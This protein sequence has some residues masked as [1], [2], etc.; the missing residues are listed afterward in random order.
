M[1]H[2]IPSYIQASGCVGSADSFVWD[3][4]YSHIGPEGG[5]KLHNVLHKLPT[6]SIIALGAATLEWVAWRLSALVDVQD[7]LDYA[8]SV[9]AWTIHPY[10]LIRWRVDP[11]DDPP[12]LSALLA[13]VD[14]MS[15]AVLTSFWTSKHGPDMEVFHLIH[16]TRH[17]MP[18]VDPFDSWLSLVIKRLESLAFEGDVIQHPIGFQ[19]VSLDKNLNCT[20][21]ENGS[22]VDDLV[23]SA[24]IIDHDAEIE[25]VSVRGI[26]LP[27]EVFDPSIDYNPDQ[28]IELIERFL[29]SL[30]WK[31][32][33]FLRSPASIAKARGFHG[34]PYTI[35]G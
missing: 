2:T 32:N 14:M 1:K 27:P 23:P 17:I 3:S 15:E 29:K 6:C 24:Q 19:E 12:A 20:L 4:C 9:K 25:S 18:D 30:N 31:N 28:R 13:A 26:A 7:A 8:V 5:T 35:T 16:I 11:P 10:Y 33:Q 22:S 34:I 21:E